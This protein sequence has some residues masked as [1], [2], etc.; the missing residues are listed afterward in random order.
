MVLFVG[1]CPSKL[2]KDPDVAFVGSK[3]MPVLEKWIKKIKP[4]EYGMLNSHTEFLLTCIEVEH[5][6]GAIIVTLG[7]NASKRLEKIG[8]PH[9]KLPHPSPRNRKL[10]DP[11]FID[12][13]L[14]K[15]KT[16]L[17]GKGKCA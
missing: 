4:K 12:S 14:K 17:K 1:D 7:N 9:F 15:C 6:L 5:N 8:I 13:E 16:Y 2:N 10:N 11:N 3:S